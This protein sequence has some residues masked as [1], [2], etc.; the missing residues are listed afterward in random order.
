MESDW[1]PMVMCQRLLNVTLRVNAN[2]KRKVHLHSRSLQNSI[3]CFLCRQ[4][5]LIMTE[6]S[7]STSSSLTA[8]FF[9]AIDGN[10]IEDRLLDDCAK[11]FS[12]HYGVWG[13]S[14]GPY[15]SGMFPQLTI[16]K[17]IFSFNRKTCQNVE[18]KASRAVPP[19]S[20]ELCLGRLFRL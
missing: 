6:P 16:P 1:L 9:K 14:A 2:P 15:L 10:G 3:E 19:D 17:R 5:N 13:E 18:P 7:P 8:F 12:A 20:P 11:L 4:E